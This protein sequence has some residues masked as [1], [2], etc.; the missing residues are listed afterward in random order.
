MK[1]GEERLER[2][3]QRW[4]QL[5]R[6][7][8]LAATIHGRHGRRRGR[9][10]VRIDDGLVLRQMA[11][12]L[13]GRILQNRFQLIHLRRNNRLQ[14]L[15]DKINTPLLQSVRLILEFR[16]DRRLKFRYGLKEKNYTHEKYPINFYNKI[17]VAFL[18]EN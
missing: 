15:A 4:K 10:A 12:H 16:S 7:G 3:F 8:I 6:D 13:H 9:L 14:L 2:A 11:H 1:L 5:R 17:L 18:L